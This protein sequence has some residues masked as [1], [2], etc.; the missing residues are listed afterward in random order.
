MEKAKKRTVQQREIIK[1]KPKQKKKYD[2]QKLCDLCGEV[3][4]TAD[5]LL[6]HKRKVH[7][8]NPVQCPK[9]PRTLVSEYYLNKHIKRK[10]ETH[11]DFICGVCGH[12]FAFK[13]ELSSHYR[14]VHDKKLR[15]AK[16][17]SCKLCDKTYKCAKS[18]LVHERSVHT[19]NWKILTILKW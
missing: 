6:T 4:K 1:E 19:G 16:V 15:P 14:K 7:Y 10:H 2:I 13:A 17:Y 18:V 8:R 5:K 9:C 3:F 11:K 12:G